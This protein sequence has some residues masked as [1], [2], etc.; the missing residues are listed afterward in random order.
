[1]YTQPSYPTIEETEILIRGR[2]STGRKFL[3]K[4]KQKQEQAS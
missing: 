3:K 1:M 2:D 4:K